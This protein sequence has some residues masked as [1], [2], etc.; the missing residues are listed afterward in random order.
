[1]SSLKKKLNAGEP[2]IQNYVRALEAKNFKLQEQ[3]GELQAENTTL[4]NR[5]RVLLK[6]IEEKGP[7]FSE[8]VELACKKK[9]KHH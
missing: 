6:Q 7:S 8:V 2:E 5:I 1:M 4:N 9:S 3:V